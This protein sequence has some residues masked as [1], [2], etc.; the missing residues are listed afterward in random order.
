MIHAFWFDFTFD[1]LDN[2]WIW[3]NWWKHFSASQYENQIDFMIRAP[4]Q[5]QIIKGVKV[6]QKYYWHTPLRFECHLPV[7]IT[8]R[9]QQWSI[10]RQKH[11]NMETILLIGERC[12]FVLPR[13]WDKEKNSESPCGIEPQ[14]I[15][16][17]VPMLYMHSTMSEVYYEVHRRA[18]PIGFFNPAVPTKIVS[19]S[20][21]PKGLYRP[22]PIP[23]IHFVQAHFLNRKE[24]FRW[25]M[26]F[27]TSID[28]LKSIVAIRREFI[29]F[30]QNHDSWFRSF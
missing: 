7:P 15:G 3:C 11:R 29:S 24:P 30:H 10:A 19:Q 21:N 14:T 17:R 26:I 8:F 25:V 5:Q 13:A 20:C 4:V 23:I 22:I 18:F 27:S 9:R 12:F 2:R 1:L 16:F 6:Y 28:P